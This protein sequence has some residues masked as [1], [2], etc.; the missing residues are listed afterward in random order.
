MMKFSLDLHNVGG[1]L[2][3]WQAGARVHRE[4]PVIAAVSAIFAVHAAFHAVH[5]F[6]PPQAGAM[7]YSANIST[8]QE[9]PCS[10]SAMS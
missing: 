2:N 5:H 8:D 9:T 1:K 7:A 6:G 3:E 4:H 10:R